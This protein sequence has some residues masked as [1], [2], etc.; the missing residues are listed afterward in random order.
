MKPFIGQSV[1]L[2]RSVSSNPSQP[3]TALVTF[4][5]GDGLVN[6][7]AWDANGY[8]LAGVCSIPYVEDRETVQNGTTYVMPIPGDSDDSKEG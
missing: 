2:F 3:E 5:H 8:P 7:A 4:I 6:V 1:Q